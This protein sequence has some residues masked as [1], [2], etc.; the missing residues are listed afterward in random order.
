MLTTAQRVDNGI[1]WLD[2]R[3]PN[4]RN[5]INWAALDMASMNDCVLGQTGG[6]SDP[7]REVPYGL[8]H[9]GFK[10]DLDSGITYEELDT[11]WRR[12]A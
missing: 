7:R 4:W 5:R 2:Y 10:N 3:R 6:W 12:R 8:S 11:E 9:Y 1:A